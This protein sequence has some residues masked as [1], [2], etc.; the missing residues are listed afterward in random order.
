[1]ERLLFLDT[2]YLGD[3]LLSLPLLEAL[4]YSGK[5]FE[6]GVV[7]TPLAQDL[8]ARRPGVV[9][10]FV[11]DKRKDKTPWG[12]YRFAKGLEGFGAAL[13]VS[14]HK[15]AR[16][17][18][19]L[20]LARVPLRVGLS[21]AK[22]SFLYHKLVP[23]DATLPVV[24]R[25]LRLLSALGLQ[26]PERCVPLSDP[27]VD[28]AQKARV[29]TMLA[30][31]FGCMPFELVGVAPGSVWQTKRWPVEHFTQ[32]IKMFK[33]RLGMEC[34]LV[35]GKEDRTIAR[36]IQKGLP[37]PV[38]DFTGRTTIGEMFA[39]V[40]S[41]KLLVSNDS[42]PMHVAFLMGVPVVGVF[43]PTIRAFGFAPFGQNACV[44]EIDLACRPCSRH[45]GRR[46]PKGHF[47]CM[48]GLAAEKVFELGASLLVVPGS[49]RGK[50]A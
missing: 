19:L 18:L 45:G 40:Q 14:A 9:E 37:F 30:Q 34:V 47:L 46:C 11:W 33:V 43:G 27:G 36:E 3:C 20:A 42:A 17:A 15:S 22:L 29:Q 7:T 38:A 39:A 2:A 4:A 49:G 50:R 6:I 24:K 44:A 23:E 41:F 26:V 16:S 10:V 35:G 8:F 1:M 21:T 25:K 48:R 28:P 12:L 5:S 32:L 13:A 31:A